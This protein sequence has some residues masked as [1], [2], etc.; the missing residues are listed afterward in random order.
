MIARSPRRSRL[1]ESFP[2][3][4]HFRVSEP[5]ARRFQL[6]MSRFSPSFLAGMALS[7]ADL[8]P[9][10]SRAIL[11]GGLSRMSGI[12]SHV[13]VSG[14]GNNCSPESAHTLRLSARLFRDSSVDV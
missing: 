7:R 3:A 14:R 11:A 5:K 4:V 1:G 13:A 6:A 12:G 2:V 9:A 8:K 10:S